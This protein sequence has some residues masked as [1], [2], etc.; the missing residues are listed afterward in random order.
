[1]ANFR[2]HARVLDLLGEEQIAD[3]PTAIS[4]L[5]KNA[6][7]AYAHEAIL[8]LYIGSGH[9]ILW[10]DGFGMSEHDL[11]SR[12]LVVGTP[13]KKL[14]ERRLKVPEGRKPRPIM[15]EKGIGRL[16]ISR[17]GDCLLLVTRKPIEGRDLPPDTQ[18]THDVGRT[19]FSALFLN[20]N[21]AKNLRLLLEDIEV[22]ILNFEHLEDL[23]AGIVRDMVEE[24]RRA[25]LEPKDAAKWAGAEMEA[26]RQRIVEQCDRFRPDMMA[27]RRTAVF[28]KPS[29]TA[30]F[31]GELHPDLETYAA[32]SRLDKEREEASRLVLLLS[33]FSDRFSLTDRAIPDEP[34]DRF[35]ID[36]RRWRTGEHA[37]RSLFEEADAFGPDDLE[38][39]DHFIN[40]RF[41]EYGS[42]CSADAHLR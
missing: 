36:I 41:D 8:D 1:M 39:R 20:W 22:P 17:L 21:I 29:G 9:A 30:F 2:V 11:E 4:E 15:G 37:P 12:W 38:K 19:P 6:Y 24:F 35:D 7:D 42:Y 40:V 27:L 31:I 13:S 33:N 32:P 14:A 23:D 34:H 3:L 25:V 10:D 16:A 18:G 28:K 5:L 26:L